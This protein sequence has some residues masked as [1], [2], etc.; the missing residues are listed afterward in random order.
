MINSGHHTFAFFLFLLLSGVIEAQ[1]TRED[2]QRGQ[3]FLSPRLDGLAYNLQWNPNW[4]GDSNR[5]WY[6]IQ[7]GEGQQFWSVDADTNTRQPAFNPK[8]LSAGLSRA[9]GELYQPESLPFEEI[10]FVEK[11]SAIR[12]SVKKLRWTCLL[13]TYE[14]SFEVKE[15]ENPAEVK[16]PDGK[17]VAFLKDHNIHIRQVE[18]G[19]IVQLSYDGQEGY[20]YSRRLPSPIRLIEQ[21]RMDVERQVAAVWSPDS[22]KLISYRLDQRNARRFT[23]VQSVPRNG[24]RPLR[25]TYAYPLPGEIGLSRAEPVIFDIDGGKRMVET[26]PLDLLYYG[27][28]S[29]S[30]FEDGQRFFFKY[31][32][33]GYKRVQIRAVDARTGKSRVLVEERGET[34]VDP[35]MSHQYFLDDG[36][37]IVWSSE[38][39]GWC[40]LYLYDGKSGRLKGQ[41]TRGTWVVRGIEYV[42]EE[43]RRVYFTA[44]GR[45]QGRDP[46]LRH[47]YRVNLD[48]QDLRLL[49]PENADHSVSF[50]PSGEFFVDTY[51]RVDLPPVWVLRRSS[52]GQVVRELEKTDISRLMA[53]GWK[54]PLPFQAKARDGFTN[55]YGVMWW[56]SNFDSSRKYPVVEQIYTGPHDFHVPKTFWGRRSSESQSLAELGFVVVMVDGMGTGRRSRSFGDFSYKNLGDGGLEDHIAALYQ[57]AERHPYLDLSRVGI[58]GHSAGGYDSAHALLTHPEFYKVAVSSS[59]NHDHRMDKAW[60]NELWMGFP[61]EDHYR[62]QSNVTLAD[63]LEGKLL[64]VHGELD[65]NVHPASTLQLVNAL[66]K[67]NKDFDLLI[68]PGAHHSL[69]GNGYFIRRRWDYFVKHLLGVEP[70]QGFQIQLK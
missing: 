25:Y 46:Y 69:R 41:I 5:F 52:D 40:H 60:W 24:L 20:D 65:E 18:T 44:G 29:F 1:G 32:E 19:E 53:A 55:V 30:W 47:L 39:D 68:V 63:R 58:F 22:R 14:C 57:L 37:E 3:R 31:T 13:A 50:S 33:R 11:E 9:T 66:V 8:R 56:P 7:T 51:S 12:F 36:A 35:Y 67:A 64:L 26:E 48:G 62:Q 54:E 59:G 34:H 4:I 23:L 43:R 28:P 21:G 61:V 27:G 15:E 49:T 38:R 6:R 10:E 17:W 2:Y 45:E 42:D 16:S 70:P